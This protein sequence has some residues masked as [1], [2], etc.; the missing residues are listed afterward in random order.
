MHGEEVLFQSSRQ[1]PGS[2]PI[3]AI[4]VVVEAI[5][6]SV[7]VVVQVGRSRRGGGRSRNVRRIALLA[8]LRIDDAV[9]A[10]RL[11]AAVGVAAVA[12]QVVAVVA[13]LVRILDA[14]AAARERAVVAAIVGVVGVAV[15][16][17]LRRVELAVA[18]VRAVL[19][20]GLPVGL[21]RPRRVAA[22]GRGSRCRHRR[23]RAPARRK[24][25]ARPVGRWRFMFLMSTG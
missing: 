13:A 5:D 20:A 8:E 3:A 19:T 1:C 7:A 17:L 11:E 21:D 2:R 18:A 25:R 10:E 12:V 24:E 22:L 16:A 14:I 23:T 15:V 4:A 6:L 9:T